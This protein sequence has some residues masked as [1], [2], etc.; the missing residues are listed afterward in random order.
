MK[1]F[2]GP[3]ARRIGVM[4]PPAL[5]AIS[6]LAGLTIPAALLAL[7]WG[8]WMYFLL[9]RKQAAINAAE[10]Q[11]E[12]CRKEVIHSQKL[13]SIGQLSAGVA[14]EINTPLNIIPSGSGAD[15]SDDR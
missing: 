10:I 1:L 6:A 2:T 3:D 12:T 15:F 13:A 5:S 4:V 9:D 8:A 14:H 11:A 7:A